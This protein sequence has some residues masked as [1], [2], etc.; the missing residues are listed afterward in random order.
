MEKAHLIVIVQGRGKSVT[1]GN[2]NMEFKRPWTRW[3]EIKLDN[4]MNE[5]LPGQVHCI[6]GVNIHSLFVRHCTAESTQDW[7]MH[8]IVQPRGG[9]A[10]IRGNMP[11]P[12]DGTTYKTKN[13]KGKYFCQIMYNGN[14][15]KFL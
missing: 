7:P 15:C 6:P 3:I 4:L 13:F 8:K 1:S 10:Q 12:S 5:M 9:Q 2:E 11:I 14:I